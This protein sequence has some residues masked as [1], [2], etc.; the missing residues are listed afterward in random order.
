MITSYKF[1][2]AWTLALHYNRG[3][4]EKR[5]GEKNMATLAAWFL[6]FNCLVGIALFIVSELNDR[7]NS[8]QHLK[9]F[10]IKLGWEPYEDDLW[11]HQKTGVVVDFQNAIALEL[12]TSVLEQK[13]FKSHTFK[14]P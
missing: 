4:T 14:E 7:I 10:L 1:E 9:R 8:R 2:I 13:A 5:K 12:Q 6:I 3:G 11:R